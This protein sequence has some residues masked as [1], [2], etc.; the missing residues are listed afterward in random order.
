MLSSCDW[1][2]GVEFSAERNGDLVGGERERVDQRG[3]GAGSFPSQESN[4]T[5]QREGVPIVLGDAERGGGG[6]SISLLLVGL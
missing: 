6:Q 5:R 3:V 1:R 4:Q 2:V